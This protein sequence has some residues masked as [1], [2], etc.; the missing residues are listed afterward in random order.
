MSYGDLYPRLNP[1]K[2]YAQSVLNLLG[3]LVGTAIIF[4]SFLVIGWC[5][6]YLLFWLHGIHP[7]PREIFEFVSQLEMMVMY[8]DAFLCFVVLVAGITKFIKELFSR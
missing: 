5:I 4:A 8:A 7:F 2:S 3:H 1:P 6:S